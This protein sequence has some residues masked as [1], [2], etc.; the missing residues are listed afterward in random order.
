V[1]QVRQR[2][3]SGAGSQA[4]PE[5]RATD[6]LAAAVGPSPLPD[7]TGKGSPE[8]T[9]AV[10]QTSFLT[11]AVAPSPLPGHRVVR[12][13][14]S[15]KGVESDECQRRAARAARFSSGGANPAGGVCPD[16]PINLTGESPMAKAV[17]AAAGARL[18][19][20]VGA[21]SREESPEVRRPRNQIHSGSA[22][23]CFI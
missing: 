3:G 2:S 15:P 10:Q 6:S 12:I 21:G 7:G 13:V 16:A 20:E 22:M 11:E 14:A 18:A 17:K 1:R 9:S 5:L 19:L 8:L 23:K 4:S